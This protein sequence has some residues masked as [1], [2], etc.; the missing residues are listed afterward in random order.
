MRGTLPDMTS[1]STRYLRLLSIYRDQS[2]WAVERIASRVKQVRNMQLSFVFISHMDVFGRKDRS[3]SYSGFLQPAT[4]S[5][6]DV[7]NQ[8]DGSNTITDEEQV[9][10]CIHEE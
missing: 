9:Y 5:R 8:S 1:D 3:S 2:D 10:Y 7:N 6:V 4:L